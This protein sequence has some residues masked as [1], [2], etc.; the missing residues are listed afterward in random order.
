MTNSDNARRFLESLH[1][2]D[3]ALLLDSCEV[4]LENR[5]YGFEV[6]RVALV[7]APSPIDV[8]TIKAAGQLLTQSGPD[9]FGRSDPQ[10][11]H[12]EECGRLIPSTKKSFA[13]RGE[14]S[15]VVSGSQWRFLCLVRSSVLV[16]PGCEQSSPPDIQCPRGLQGKSVM[17]WQ[18]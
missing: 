13:S 11:V 9:R 7:Q 5:R 4:S 16:A 17:Y 8:S 12:L 18:G 3:V 1:R 10:S 2:F 14:T 6:V 15:R